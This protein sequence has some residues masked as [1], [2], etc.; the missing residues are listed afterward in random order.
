MELTPRRR[1]GTA[2]YSISGLTAPAWIAQL[3]WAFGYTGVADLPARRTIHMTEMHSI[4][5]FQGGRHASP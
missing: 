3:T 4:L 1:M 2:G 5:K